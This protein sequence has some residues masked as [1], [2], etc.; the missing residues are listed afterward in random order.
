[1]FTSGQDGIYPPGI[2]IGD[3]VSVVTGSATTPH[4]ILIQPAAKLSAMQEVGILL[5]EPPPRAEFEQKLPNST[6]K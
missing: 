4:Q 3:I 2:K 5:Y 6:K 1:V